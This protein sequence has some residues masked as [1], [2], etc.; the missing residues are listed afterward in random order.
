MPATTISTEAGVQILNNVTLNLL[1]NAAKFTENGTVTLTAKRV[2]SPEGDTLVF[3]VEDSGV[4]MD[5]QGVEQA[6]E[7][8]FRGQPSRRGGHGVGLTIVRRFSDR[9]HWP[10]SV[11][12]E[13][14]VGTRVRVEFPDAECQPA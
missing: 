10:V 3:T 9:F 11:N 14:G 13:P 4:G 6:F 12:S 5:A 1:S 2:A 7:P 8:F